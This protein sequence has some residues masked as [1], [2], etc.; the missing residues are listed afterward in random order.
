MIPVF[1][2]TENELAGYRMTLFW[3]V[4]GRST[5]DVQKGHPARPQPM[6]APEA[7][8]SHPPNPEL[9]E[10]RF[11]RVG[12]AEDAFEARTQP[13]ERRVLARRGWAGEK[14]RLFQRPV[15]RS[16]R[17]CLGG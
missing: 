14:G 12:Y 17:R 8:H 3:N 2:H 6:K 7:S 9:L 13:V 11:S 10:Q 5:Q 15:N 16:R 1:L 4:R